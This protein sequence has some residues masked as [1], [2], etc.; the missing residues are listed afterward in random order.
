MT[1]DSVQHL[2]TLDQET[3]RNM[4]LVQLR[5]LLEWGLFSD[6]APRNLVGSLLEAIACEVVLTPPT[7]PGFYPHSEWATQ[8]PV[9]VGVRLK[10]QAH[11]NNDGPGLLGTAI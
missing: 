11:H 4:F 10:A 5:S 7:L 2:Q 8:G 1:L 6:S 9:H 3:K